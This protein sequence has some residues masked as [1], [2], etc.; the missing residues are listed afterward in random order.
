MK[1]PSHRRLYH[2]KTSISLMISRR[3][4]RETRAGTAV[5][6]RWRA[7]QSMPTK[8]S[9]RNSSFRIPGST[10]TSRGGLFDRTRFNSS[11]ITSLFSRTY[12]WCSKAYPMMRMVSNW[13]G[14]KTR[15]PGMGRWAIPWLSVSSRWRWGFWTQQKWSN[16][17]VII[18]IGI[19][20]FKTKATAINLKHRSTVTWKNSWV[21]EGVP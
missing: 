15:L 16:P 17:G 4:L 21:I 20:R 2:R 1:R 10:A 8:Y 14:C 5:W 18:Q 7:L 19:T 3:R 11:S 13:Q 6:I 12:R 9:D